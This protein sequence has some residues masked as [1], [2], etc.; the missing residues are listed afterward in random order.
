MPIYS[1]RDVPCGIGNTVWCRA[2]ESV[3]FL[4]MIKIKVLTA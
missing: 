4:Y 2:S 1:D 3:E